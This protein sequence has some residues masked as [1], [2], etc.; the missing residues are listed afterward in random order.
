MGG[1]LNKED[2]GRL[3]RERAKVGPLC[4]KS[5]RVL[6][7]FSLFHQLIASIRQTEGGSVSRCEGLRT[8][9]AP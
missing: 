2:G 8:T 7:S 6:P 4:K 5:A 1:S 9:A 3:G